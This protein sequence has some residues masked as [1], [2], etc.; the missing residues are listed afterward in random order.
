MSVG[1]GWLAAIA[2]AGVE[3]AP[4]SNSGGR[5]IVYALK[6]VETDGL[7]WRESAYSQLQPVA[8]QGAAT[9]WT[10]PRE[11]V[12][13]IVQH[14][15]Q[16]TKGSILQAPKVTGGTGQP[17]HISTRST[18][19]MITQVAWRGEDAAPKVTPENVRVG[20]M[21]T[22]VG[23]KLDQGVLV[24]IVMEDTQILAVHKVMLGKCAEAKV[25]AGAEP[26]EL[27]AI[28]CKSDSAKIAKV[29]A[30]P[31]DSVTK[32][33]AGESWKTVKD[34]DASK[35]AV[36]IP[37]VGGQEVAGEWLVPNDG[38]LLIS[39]GVHTMTGADGKAVVRERLAVLE[40]QE[41]QTAAAVVPA[42]T[43]AINIPTLPP[44]ALP[45]IQ[46]L[47]VPH[48]ALGHG[49][50]KI[51]ALPGRSIPEGMHADGTAAEAP[52]V[53]D[54]EV[55]LD[56]DAET[57]EPAPSAQMKSR[58]IANMSERHTMDAEGEGADD[59][60]RPASGVQAKKIPSPRPSFDLGTNKVEFTLPK[61]PQL[62]A[63]LSGGMAPMSGLQFMMP[64]KPLAIKLPFNQK[65]EIEVIGKIVPDPDTTAR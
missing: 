13:Q 11:V 56:A 17:V 63:W 47:R 21:A 27:D 28:D 24:Q 9:V 30:N 51:P 44:P 57:S 65:L 18:R 38:I 34:A 12:A 43:G 2:L 33:F 4:D 35:L 45:T 20:T 29:S 59:T 41:G 36:E 14:A 25:C 15:A 7:G 31:N 37:E 52:P 26:S 6:L 54:D 3:P 23:R 1:L 10:A 55:A 42:S 53:P 49:P 5:D 32:Y 48:V 22:M 46:P 39:L 60:A 64:I 8:R 16:G 40:A 61:L 50:L 19:Q 62:P 58:Q